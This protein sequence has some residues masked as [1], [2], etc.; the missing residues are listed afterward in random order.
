MRKNFL[1]LIGGSLKGA[2]ET[3]QN[4]GYVRASKKKT[5]K[6]VDELV[7]KTTKKNFI[8]QY[9]RVAYNKAMT[10]GSIRNVWQ[11]KYSELRNRIRNRYKHLR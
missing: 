6:M 1:Q 3:L 11:N 5:K 10:P 7:N 4:Y 9:G 8:K 2:G